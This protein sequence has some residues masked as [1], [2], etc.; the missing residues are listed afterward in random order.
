MNRTPIWFLAGYLALSS[1]PFATATAQ[2]VSITQKATG[3]SLDATINGVANGVV[4]FTLEGGRHYEL[5]ASQ[6]TEDS[7]ERIKAHLAAASAPSSELLSTFS[8]LN[9]IVGHELFG[10]NASIW[11]ENAGEVA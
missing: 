5:P 9:D 8:T 1:C 7:I 4:S 6:L 2:T 11:E 10:E 3:K